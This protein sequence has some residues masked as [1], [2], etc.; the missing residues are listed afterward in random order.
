MMYPPLYILRHGQTEWNAQLRIQG[1]LDS[2]LSDLG[3]AQAKQQHEIL[4]SRDLSGYRAFCSPQGRAFH[5]ASIALDGLCPRIDTDPR[6]V[7]IGVGAWEGLRRDQLGTDPHMDETEEGALDLYERAPGGEGFDAL[8]N[9]C[10][11]FLRDLTGPA[12]LVTHGITSRMLRLIVLDM[13]THEIAD[14]PGG[15]GVVF[16]LSDGLQTKL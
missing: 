10:T 12:V 6:L 2:P 15:Q 11:A 9:R 13:E 8:R 4:R 14:L 7:E 5:T 16:H 1:S 3:R